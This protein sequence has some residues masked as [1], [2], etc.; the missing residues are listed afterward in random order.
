MVKYSKA[1]VICGL[2]K[3][4]LA[5]RH[6]KRC[7]HLVFIQIEHVLLEFEK[8]SQKASGYDR[9]DRIMNFLIYFHK[10]FIVAENLPEPV[11]AISF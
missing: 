7:F 9:Y 1:W 8:I 10:Q 5:E 11:Y 4:E 2:Q 6:L 3:T